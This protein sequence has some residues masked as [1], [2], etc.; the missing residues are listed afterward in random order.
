M[1]PCEYCDTHFINDLKGTGLF[2]DLSFRTL[3]ATMPIEHYK[4]SSEWPNLILFDTLSD[5]KEGNVL[6]ALE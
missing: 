1:L 6:L 3:N 4:N 5:L 2:G